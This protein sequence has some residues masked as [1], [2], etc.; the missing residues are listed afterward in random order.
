MGVIACM[1]ATVH[2]GIFLV[3]SFSVLQGFSVP[4][5]VIVISLIQIFRHPT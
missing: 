5:F 4:V 1:A 2:G 3:M